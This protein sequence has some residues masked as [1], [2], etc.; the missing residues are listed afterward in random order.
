MGGGGAPL[1]ERTMGTRSNATLAAVLAALTYF[2]AVPAAETA[3]DALAIDDR[4][5]AFSV[6]AYWLAL[7][8]CPSNWDVS[9]KQLKASHEGFELVCSAK[10]L[11]SY[12]AR[13]ADT[14]APSVARSAGSDEVT[15]L[16]ASGQARVI[17]VAD[18]SVPAFQRAW[19]FLARS[20]PRASES[21]DAEFQRAVTTLFQGLG[22]MVVCDAGESSGGLMHHIA[23]DREGLTLVC[24]PGHAPVRVRFDANRQPRLERPLLDSPWL[25]L[26]NT[27]GR[28]T[29]LWALGRGR[30]A[31][32]EEGWRLLI[33]WSEAAAHAETAELDAVIAAYRAASPKPELP[34]DARRFKVQAEAAVRE[35]RYAD[36]AEAFRAALKLA[37]WWP[38]GRFNRA[39]ILAEL[40]RHAEAI[41]EMK[42]YLALVPD[43][44]NARHAQDKVYEWEAAARR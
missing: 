25:V 19:S 20:D 30:A 27:N 9:V 38:Q 41:E 22:P 29:H 40:G 24:E 10:S 12:T 11:P 36:A 15:V 28:E 43:A 23:F 32:L 8:G 37:P 31:I 35:Q 4:L 21:T 42:R 13:Y 34:E 5:A 14:P 44:A 17:K 39:L 16:D 18:Q 2:P 7:G 26:R 6:V 33:Q 1:S 3:A